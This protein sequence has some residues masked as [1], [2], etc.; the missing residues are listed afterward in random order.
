MKQTFGS[1]GNLYVGSILTNNVLRYNGK[2]GA[3]I[4]VFVPAGSGGLK[5]P[6]FLYFTKDAIAVPESRTELALLAFVAT[7]S[8][9]KVIRRFPNDNN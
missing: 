8:V 4:D 5:K 6:R 1:D 3:F 7:L 2:T 9:G